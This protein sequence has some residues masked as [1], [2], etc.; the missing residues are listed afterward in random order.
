MPIKLLR[1]NL[2]RIGDK[3]VMVVAVLGQQSSGKS[4]LL[5]FLFGCDFLSSDGRCTSGVYGTY[6]ELNNMNIGNCEGVLLLDTEGLFSN[7]EYKCELRKHFDNKLVL[8]LLKVCDIVILNSRSDIDV[9]CQNILELAF[10]C[11]LMEYKPGT[12]YPN[13]FIVLNQTKEKMN[14]TEEQEVIKVRD[15]ILRVA[16]KMNNFVGLNQSTSLPLAFNTIGQEHMSKVLKELQQKNLT[17]TDAFYTCTKKFALELIKTLRT[18]GESEGRTL[19]G[20]YEDMYRTWNT[21]TTN[22][23]LTKYST[24]HLKKKEEEITSWKVEQAEET[25]RLAE[26]YKK[27]IEE[28]FRGFD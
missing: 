13:L 7:F 26:E 22:P 25:Q 4:T 9:K 24:R 28:E 6:Y 18:R 3:K 27:N 2:D 1:S 20:A 11:D 21:I 15:K 16:P 5:N 10:E 14:S 12:K 23:L 17:P 8:F 19:E